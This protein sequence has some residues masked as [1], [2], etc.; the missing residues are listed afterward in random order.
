MF[1]VAVS[2]KKS[3]IDGRGVFADKA[4]VEGSIVWKFDPDHDFTLSQEEFD[5]LGPGAKEKLSHVAYFSPWTNRWV[6]PPEGDAAEYTNHSSRNNLKVVYNETISPEPY[7][8]ANRDIE[9]GE[10]LT[11]NYLEFD[12][13]TQKEKPTWINK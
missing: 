13:I 1:V 5:V 10:E 7:F 4:V 9:A 6:C 12:A 2:I 11:N 3:T 8:V